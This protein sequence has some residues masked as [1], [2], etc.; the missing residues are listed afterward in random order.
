MYIVIFI[1]LVVIISCSLLFLG[2]IVWR[3]RFGRPAGNY[4]PILTYHKVDKKFEL[5]GTWT[6]PEQFQ[7]HMDYLKAKGI[8][9][10]TLSRAVELMKS[11][12]GRNKKH[13]CLTFDDAYEGLYN[14]AWP[15]LQKHGFLA[16]IFVV[17]DYV[18]REND[19]DVNWGGRKFRHLGWKQIIEMSEAGIEFGSHTRTHQD[20]RRLDDEELREELAGAKNILE[21]YLGQKIG[22]LSYP[23]GRYD[24]RVMEAAGEYGYE[25]ACSLSPQMKNNQ[26]NFMALRRSAIYIT[27]MMWN[28][29]NKIF[30]EGRFFWLQDLWCRMVNFCAGGTIVVQNII[31]LFRSSPKKF[32]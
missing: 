19:W 17:T 6:T 20:L 21:K 24:Q 23:F 29:R 8:T 22:T 5:G 26:I 11:G 12:E 16:T 9:P 25:A 4:I 27:D 31:K 30:Q 7:K 13:I 18:G 14:Y 3:A 10:V 32:E 1:I 28:Y 15:I 2:Y